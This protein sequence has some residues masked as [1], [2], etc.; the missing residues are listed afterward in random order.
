MNAQF[1]GLKF[2]SEIAFRIWIEHHWYYMISLYDYKQDLSTI[3]IH[4]TGEILACD[5]SQSVYIGKFVDVSFIVKGQP[6]R[7]FNPNTLQYDTYKGLVIEAVDLN[8]KNI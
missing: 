5:F 4:K 2:P 1:K 6:L 3:W 7:I 8:H